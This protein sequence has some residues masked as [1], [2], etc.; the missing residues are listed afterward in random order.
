MTHKH[1]PHQNTPA[2]THKENMHI[3]TLLVIHTYSTM[4]LTIKILHIERQIYGIITTRIT[5]PYWN[6]ND[7]ITKSTTYHIRQ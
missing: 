1:V 4:T 5:N 6:L 2:S 3:E 7:T